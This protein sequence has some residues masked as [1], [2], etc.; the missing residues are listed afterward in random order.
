MGEEQAMPKIEHIDQL[1]EFNDVAFV[2]AAYQIV[3]GRAPDP[4]GMRY[5]LKR[6]RAGFSKFQIV[7]Q[8]HLS[9][10]GLE[11]TV[12][13]PGMAIAL[14]RYR[15]GQYPLAGWLFRLVERTEGNG[16]AERTLRAIEQQSYQLS[17]E[18]NNHFHKM[19]ATIAG[20]RYLVSER[21]GVPQAIPKV[22]INAA[23]RDGYRR[24]SPAAKDVYF[25]LKAAA[26]IHAGSIETCDL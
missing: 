5:Y 18:Y 1:M 4:E 7:S 25:Q 13:L 3:L 10:E 20:L 21:G 17:E 23:E 26:A 2:S 19:E 12:N 16:V 6:L 24:L 22:S 15:R 11:R 14:R 9:K 8:L